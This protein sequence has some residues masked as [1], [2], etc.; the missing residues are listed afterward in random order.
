MRDNDCRK[1]DHKSLEALRLRT[2]DQVQQGAHPEEVAL[3]LGLH[4]KTGWK[5]T[6]D[7]QS[8]ART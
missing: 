8:Q 5:L 2:V 1:L 4:C 7:D 6:T 3:A